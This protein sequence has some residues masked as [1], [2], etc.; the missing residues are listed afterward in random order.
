MPG[1][2]MHAAPP[3][4]I[5]VHGAAHAGALSV[6]VVVLQN[7]TVTSFGKEP[8]RGPSSGLR[9]AAK[10]SPRRVMPEGSCASTQA[11]ISSRETM[12]TCVFC[13]QPGRCKKIHITL[14]TIK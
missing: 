8:A 13:R 10:G 3:I 12:P 6:L 7:V 5:V 1:A 4:V 11:F 14:I 2:L 9:R